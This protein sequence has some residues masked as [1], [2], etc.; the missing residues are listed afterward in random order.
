ML[1]RIRTG[2]IYRVEEGIEF[3]I[4]SLFDGASEIDEKTIECGSEIVPAV[5]KFILE[6]NSGTFKPRKVVKEL[7]KILDRHAIK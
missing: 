4:G 6:V 5:E 3:P 1:I 2:I 7:E